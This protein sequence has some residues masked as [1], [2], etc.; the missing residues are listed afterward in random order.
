MKAAPP[1][2]RGWTLTKTVAAL[3]TQGSPAHAGMDLGPPTT[4]ADRRRLPRTRGDGPYVATYT[5]G[6]F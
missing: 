4:R 6:V 2:T 3:A 1:H 5:G